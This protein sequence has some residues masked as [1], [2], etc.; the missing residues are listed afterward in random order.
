M[1]EIKYYKVSKD[2]YFPVMVKAI[3]KKQACFIAVCLCRIDEVYDYYDTLL[4][5]GKVIRVKYKK[6]VEYYT[7]SVIDDFK[8][9]NHKYKEEKQLINELNEDI[10]YGSTIGK[11]L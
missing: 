9:K 5:E 6:G 11:W 2:G 8:I 1:N 4:K 7:K 10:E 3:S